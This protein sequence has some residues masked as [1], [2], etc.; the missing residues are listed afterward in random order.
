VEERKLSNLPAGQDE[1][2]SAS[3]LD[4][5][6]F[7]RTATVGGAAAAAL[8]AGGLSIPALGAT[9]DGI[10]NITSKNVPTL[11]DAGAGMHVGIGSV[12]MIACA[13]VS[14]ELSTCQVGQMGMDLDQLSVLAGFLEPILGILLGPGFSGPF[15]MSMFSLSQPTYNVNHAAGT[16]FGK[17]IIRSITKVAG[18][19]IEDATAP[20]QVNATDGSRTGQRDS[21]FLS[22]TTPFWKTPGNPLATPSKF[23]KGWSMFGGELILG[24]I[25]VTS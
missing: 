4:R 10:H 25:S 3:G 5:R 12:Q 11:K 20:F 22:F 16:I 23:H 18:I 13:T 8:A 21:F 6:S 19:T 2:T 14:R 24:E 1:S 17:G 7:V 9:R 15:A